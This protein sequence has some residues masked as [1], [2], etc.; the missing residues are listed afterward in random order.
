MMRLVEIRG[1]DG[2]L[3]DNAMVVYFPGPGSFTG[4]DCA[5]FHLHGS[6]AVV[7]TLQQELAARDGFRLAEPGE[8]TLRAFRNGRVDLTEAEALSDLISAETELQRQFALEQGAG[9]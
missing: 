3:I 8:F 1:A 2:S 4:E 9:R 5:E 7:S 6:R